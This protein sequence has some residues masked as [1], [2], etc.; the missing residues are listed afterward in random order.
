[1]DPKSKPPS[2]DTTPPGLFGITI[3]DR[4]HR[5]LAYLWWAI[6]VIL[7]IVYYLDLAHE[8]SM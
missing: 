2:R 6:L 1:M 4:I 7:I 5:I 3:T 8:A